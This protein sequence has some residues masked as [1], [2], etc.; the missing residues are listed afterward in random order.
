[1]SQTDALA[2]QIAQLRR[3][4][5]QAHHAG[6]SDTGGQYLIFLPGMTLPKGWSKTICTAFFR[7]RIHEP[8]ASHPDRATA[9]PLNGFFVDIQDLRLANGSFPHYTTTDTPTLGE[10]SPY[11]KKPV[12]YGHFD[13]DD[14]DQAAEKVFRIPTRTY[15]DLRHWPQWRGLTRF[16][17]RAQASNPNY[18]TLFTAAML[19]RQRLSYVR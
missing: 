15:G 10:V 8:C 19:V 6:E 12:G 17:W 9:S 4:W 3:K 11:L 16:F 2:E 13:Q 5:P 7:V 1:M 14:W 18:D